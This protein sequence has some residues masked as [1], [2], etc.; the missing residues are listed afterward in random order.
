MIKQLAT[1]GAL[2]ILAL[3]SLANATP[4]VGAMAPDFEATDIA[5]NAFKLSDHKGDIVILEWTNHECPFVVKHYSTGNMQATQKDTRAKSNE[6][7]GVKWVSI[8]SSA[9]GKQGHVTPQEAQKIVNEAGAE[10]DVKILDETGTI[11]K[12]Y[13]AKTT[14]H[15]YIID[16]KG[17]LVYAG[18]IDSNSSP[19]P[20]TIEG[21]EN[22]VL[23]AVNELIAGNTVTT[24]Q[25]K[26][27]GCSVK[28]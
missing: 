8:V 15:M 26:P 2:A 23:A 24:A 9:P 1:L 25:T 4:E 11:G 21:S 20:A 28:Y 5:G 27:Y 13:D 6:K 22:Y 14:P 17:T 12:L 19:N 16:A 7:Q 3:P 18:A 10:V